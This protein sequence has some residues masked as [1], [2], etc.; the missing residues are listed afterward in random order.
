MK[1]EAQIFPEYEE[2]E[3][4][5]EELVDTEE[6]ELVVFNDDVNTFDH[7][8]NVLVKVCRHTREQAEQCTLI[9]H[10]K[11]KCAVKKGTRTQLKPMCQAILDAGIEAAI[12]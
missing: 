7:V 8:I 4:L 5:V 10:Y 6:C 9:I 1:I 3:L 2:A 12:L 11:G